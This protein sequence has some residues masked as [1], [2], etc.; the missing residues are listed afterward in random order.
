MTE[1]EEDK[2]VASTDSSRSKAL[3]FLNTLEST[4]HNKSVS[5]CL[6]GT[7]CFEHLFKVREFLRMPGSSTK[8]LLESVALVVPDF[9]N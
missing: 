5:K 6:F 1:I 3:N 9:K 4:L 2:E 7:V 8:T